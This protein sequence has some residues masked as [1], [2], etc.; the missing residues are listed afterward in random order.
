MIVLGLTGSIAMG[1]STA[2]DLLRRLGVAVHDSDAAVHRIMSRG[3][4]AIAAVE[5]AFPGVVVEGTIDR[6]KL[7]ARVFGD[8]EALRQLE[9]ILHPLVRASADRFLKTMARRH[10]RFVALDVPLLFET[11]GERRCDRTIVVWSP[12]FLQRQR[13]LRRPGMTE[14]R[15]AQVLRQQMPVRLK[16]RKADAAIA[17]GLGRRETYLGLKRV[18]RSWCQDRQRVWSPAYRRR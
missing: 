11:G 14:E 6:A 3:G 4:A 9:R 1:K 7:G 18:L 8:R 15:L 12:A 2:A 16:R 10:C 17:S 5:K 13:F